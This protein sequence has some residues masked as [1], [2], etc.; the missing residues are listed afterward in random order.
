MLTYRTGA[1]GKPSSARAMAD[2]LMEQTLPR[3]KAELAR[4]YQRGM[5][6]AEPGGHTAPEPRRDMR[7]KVASLLGIDPNRPV[8]RDEVANLLNG[9]RT[10]GRAIPGKQIQRA[11]DS[12]EAVFGLDPTRLPTQ[13]E[14]ATVLAGKR[15]DGK[16][17]PTDDVGAA[18]GRFCS[19]FGVKDLEALTAAEYGNIRDGRMADGS[20][21]ALDEYRER[22]ARSKARIGYIDLCFSADKSVSLAWAFA[23][24]EAERNLI[25]QSH[26]DAVDSAMRYIETE[27]GR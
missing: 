24:T 2:H 17:L 25:A 6:P 18:A 8:G 10:D 9:Q 4:Y 27:I 11:I 13:G 20:A 16:R 5:E 7:P 12:L 26:R 15:L 21:M 23:P 3:D 14:I 22:I 1:A 19:A